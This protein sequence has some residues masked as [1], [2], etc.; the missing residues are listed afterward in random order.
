M[1][2]ISLPVKEAKIT[3]QKILGINNRFLFM[4]IGCFLAACRPAS[5]SY[6]SPIV[7]PDIPNWGSTPSNTEVEMPRRLR[8][9]LVPDEAPSR[10]GIQ[11]RGLRVGESTYEDVRNVLT[12]AGQVK[13]FWSIHAGNLTFYNEGGPFS[14]WQI[15]EV[16]FAD[17]KLAAMSISGAA[18]F[19]KTLS[20]LILKYGR[21]D[22]VTWANGYGDRSLLWAEKGLLAE[23]TVVLVNKPTAYKVILFSPVPRCSLE[24]SWIYQ[25]LPDEG[26]P[27]S[28]D[29]AID[30]TE[31]E[32]PWDVERGL[33]DCLSP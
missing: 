10:G 21:P 3:T 13:Y 7:T 31:E 30:I 29:V 16:C 25:A 28:G 6:V 11:W 32:D 15:V 18:E 33:S 23:V 19:H 27:F 2:S 12:E 4:I 24:Q 26:Q 1:V 20:M 17:G 22:R 5:V 8:C 9:E 14:D